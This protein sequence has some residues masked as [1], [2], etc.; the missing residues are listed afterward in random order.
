MSTDT[1]PPA[2]D[3]ARVREAMAYYDRWLSF[4]QRYQRI[5][6]VQAAVRLRDEVLLDTAHGYADLAGAV[7][8]TTRHLFRIASHSK[9]FTATVVLQL[10]ERGTVRLDDPAGQWV[11]W[12][13]EEGSALADA[14]L[15]ELLSHSAGVSRDSRDGDHWLLHQP[16]PDEAT[17]RAK[18]L[19]PGAA[20]LP[21]NE[22]FKYSNLGYS[23]LG[24]VIEAATG[25]SYADAVRAGVL[26]PLGLRDTGPELD[27]ARASELAT[28]YSALAYGDDRVPIE[29]VDTRAMA[30]ATGFYSTA[31]DVVDY[32][33]AHFLRDSRLLGDDSKRV[34]QHAAWD[35]GDDDGRYALGFSVTPV[36]GHSLIGH[37][38]GY[39]GH[40][41]RS[42]ADPA[43]GLAISVL[44]NAIDGPARGLAHAAVRLADLACTSATTPAPTPDAARFTGRFANLWGVLDV[45]VLG[46]RL[47]A[48]DPSGP[49][50]AEEPVPLDRLDDATLRVAGGSGFGSYGEQV[51]YER[52]GD[53]RI[54]RLRHGAVS[55]EPVEDFRLPA[56]V[57]PGG[58]P[59]RTATG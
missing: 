30:A 10:A 51:R 26:E 42:V 14:T 46:G 53:G 58:P 49:D 12:L 11:P 40:I 25:Q 50:P 34:M 37:G 41:T 55:Y 1:E 13:R 19:D 16:F 38:G 57:T 28:G 33:A 3:A 47:Y 59:E 17:L 54:V 8:L 27:P 44:T 21:R 18:L 23:L 52:A 56:R 6:G 9:T 36:G 45:A 22:R 15:R 2:L 5:P 32:L 7:A 20:V 31:R 24:L 48:I 43:A 35:T 39:P 29:H 4:Q